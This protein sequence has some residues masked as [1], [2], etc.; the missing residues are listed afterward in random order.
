M[1]LNVSNTLNQGISAQNNGQF[2][3]AARL[4]RIVLSSEP[5]NSDAYYNLGII[6]L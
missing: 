5:N 6:W 3:E 4:Y 2:Q 1:N